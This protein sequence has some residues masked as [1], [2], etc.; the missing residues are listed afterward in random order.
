MSFEQCIIE[1]LSYIQKALMH[2]SPH[3]ERRND[4]F[5]FSVE[6]P[7]YK[8]FSRLFDVIKLNFLW[9]LFSLPI[10][11]IGASTIA[12]YSVSL[13]MVDDEEGYIG[14]A[15]VKAFKANLKQGIIL[16]LFNIA[17]IYLVYLNFMLFN[18]IESNPL[19]LLLIGIIGS[20][21]FFFSFL[22]AYP[23]LARYEN[24]IVKTVK[25]SVTISLRYFGR[26]IVLLLI[27]ALT[28]FIIFYN[29]TTMFIA[30][31]MGPAFIIFTI[32]AFAKRIFQKIEKEQTE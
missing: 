19:P 8:F 32:S 10:V 30:F 12:A 6:S 28:L 24:S 7:I 29:Y 5:L 18:A 11:T 13:K 14:R 15:F 16:G 3:P 25:N 20:V 2:D 9:M 31:F 27:L 17:A 4:V 26:T 21:Y 23:L 22:Y 1:L